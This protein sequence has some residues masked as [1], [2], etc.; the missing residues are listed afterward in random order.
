MILMET[1]FAK[2]NMFHTVRKMYDI[3]YGIII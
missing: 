1:G 2:E 3:K